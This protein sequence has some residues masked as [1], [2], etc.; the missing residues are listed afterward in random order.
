MKRTLV[1]V[2]ASYAGVQLAA[3]ARELGFDGDIVLLGDE[4]DAPY[5]RP[6]LSKGFLTG[7]FA[8]ERLPLRSQAFFEE[9]RIQWRPSTRA[10]RI[11]RERKAVEL[12]DGTCVAYDHLALAT[13]ARV[14][15]LD[16]H[17]AS[18]DAVH[19]LRDLRDARRLAESARTARRAV[20]IGG[21]YIGLEA[22]ASLRQ[23]GLEVT[24]VETEPR[25]LARVASPW[26]SAFM[27]RAHAAHGVSFVFGRKVVKLHDT[28]DVVSVELDDGT[29][30]LCDLVVVGIGVIPNTELAA[31]CGLKVAG[32]I[33][34]DTHA[35]TS[36]PAIVAAGDCVSFVP[37]WAPA[38]S[39]A[40]RIES[41]QNANDMARTAAACVVGRAEPYRALPWFWSDQYDLK[42]QM[43][44][45]NAGFTDFAVRGAVEDNRFSLFYFRGE[46]LIA[47]DSIN[48][49]QDHM[50]ARKLLAN[51]AQLSLTQAGDPQFDLKTLAS[52]E[53]RVTQGAA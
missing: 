26:M 29:R 4:P 23:S 12:H 27:Q 6:P 38:G 3:S 45:V 14:R 50:L 36:D 42:L 47:V 22:A 53:P 7:S 16:C 8:E 31:E 52:G 37:H 28:Y 20:V 32:G 30:L 17:G 25:L 44:G 39:P 33:V 40:R 21:G 5:Q 2:G 43:A 15:K 46:A 11:D 49:P 51:G 10:M 9:E 1:V 41:V 34:V 24:V 48:R 13:G 18:H 35:R 19:Y